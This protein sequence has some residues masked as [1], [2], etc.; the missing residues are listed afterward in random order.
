MAAVTAVVLASPATAAAKKQRCHTRA[1]P[2]RVARKA[3]SQRHVVPCIRRAAI[4]HR[5]SFTDMLRVA[6]CESTLNPFAVG[7]GVHYGLF[8]F[9]PSTFVSTPYRRQSITSAKWNSLAAAWAWKQGRRGEWQ[10]R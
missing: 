4:H 10:C 2:E 1:C 8:Q 6:H 9:L 7:F 3:C 5:Q